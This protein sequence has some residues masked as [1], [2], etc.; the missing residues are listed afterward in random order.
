MLK[1]ENES[2]VSDADSGLKIFLI[3]MMG[4]GKSYWAEKLKKKFKAPAYDLDYLVEIMEERSIAEIFAEDGEAYFRKEES[5]M[6]RLFGEK[7][8]FVL[9]CGG[10]TPCF[11]DNMVWMNKTGITIWIDE[12]IEILVQR[13]L[14]EKTH[15]PLIKNLSDEELGAFL[16]KKSQE[17]EPFYNQAIYRLTGEQINDK[18]FEKILKKHA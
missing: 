9:S 13:L 14:K 4:S 12:S 17:R 8:K 10:G 1:K 18:A 7:K 2:A 3:G 11:N 5:K 6:L 15:R 16:L